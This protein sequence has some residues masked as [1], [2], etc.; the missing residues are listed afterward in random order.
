MQNIRT[1][2]Q[3]EKPENLKF[4]FMDGWL[5]A[6]EQ[7]LHKSWYLNSPYLAVIFIWEKPFWNLSKDFKF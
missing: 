7:L 1:F 3:T 5:V 6:N 2:I 4:I